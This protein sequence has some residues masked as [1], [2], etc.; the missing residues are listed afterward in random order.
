MGSYASNGQQ[1]AQ[2]SDLYTVIT[3]AALAHPSTNVAVQ[4]THL[5]RASELVDAALRDQFQTPLT[6]WGPDVQ[7]VVCDIA[8]YRLVCLRG[9]DPEK[10]ELYVTNYK[11]AMDT[12]K[13]WANGVRSPDVVDAS[14]NA[15]PGV[16]APVTAPQAYSPNHLRGTRRR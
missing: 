16:Q 3:A 5:L 2:P 11:M 15:A 6:T 1:Y 7:Q 9:F 13:D 8:A 12:L 10:D 4:N 14:P